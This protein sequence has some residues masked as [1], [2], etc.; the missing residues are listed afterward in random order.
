LNREKAAFGGD[1]RPQ[2][3]PLVGFWLFVK[4]TAGWKPNQTYLKLLS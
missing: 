3:E 4:A 2:P 1:F